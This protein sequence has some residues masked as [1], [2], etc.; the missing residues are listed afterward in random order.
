MV[1]ELELLVA[2]IREHLVGDATL[3]APLGDEW[4]SEEALDR[5]ESLLE[6]GDFD[7]VATFRELATR[8]RRQ[9]GAPVR[10]IETRLRDF[11][12]E[13]ALAEFR[14]MRSLDKP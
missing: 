14:A 2:G 12:F 4:V 8:L 5:L 3:P 9:F 13:Q 7:A 1:R 11:D 10:V 6:D